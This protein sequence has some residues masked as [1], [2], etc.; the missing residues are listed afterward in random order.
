MTMG[1]YD[2]MGGDQDESGALQSPLRITK[3]VTSSDSEEEQS[4][5]CV[6]QAEG[7]SPQLDTSGVEIQEQSRLYVGQ[8]KGVS[9]QLYTSGVEIRGAGCVDDLKILSRKERRRK[10]KHQKNRARVKRKK[11]AAKMSRTG[12]MARSTWC[13][14][15][16][17]ATSTPA[18]K[19][20]RAT[21]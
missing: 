14:S 7:V 18:R 11:M 20:P 16:D 19:A 9:P 6:G 21:E 3:E 1:K 10:Y 4:R 8:A 17:S 13:P 12:S 15:P 2:N 5:L